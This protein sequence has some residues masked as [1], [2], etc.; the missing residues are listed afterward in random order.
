MNALLRITAVVNVLW[1][2]LLLAAPHLLTE[3]V[4]APVTETLGYLVAC[5]SLTLAGLCWYG[6]RAPHLNLPVIVAATTMA[7]A[8]ILVDLVG[9]L[10]ALPPEPAVF[11][12]VDLLVHVA[13]LV[14][15]LESLPRTIAQRRAA[16]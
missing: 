2:G 10:G 6:A 9:L 4:P 3:G 15:L 1:A 13:L 8:H 5:H 7:A 14:G 11:F 12:V 16:T